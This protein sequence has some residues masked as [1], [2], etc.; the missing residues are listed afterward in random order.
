MTAEAPA[1]FD[2]N[3]TAPVWPAVVAAMA[4]ALTSGGNPSSVHRAGRTARRA[5]E[6]ARAAVAA[7]VGAEQPDSVVFTSGA[8]EAN[9]LALRGVRGRRH[10]V[11]AIEH[12]SVL[13]AAEA[14]KII[15][16]LSSGVIDL[17]ALEDLLAADP[18]PALV[19]LMVANNETGAIQPVAEAARLAHA[20]GALFHCDAV[21]AAGRLPLDIDRLGADLLSLSAHKIGGPSG[22]GALVVSPA[23]AVAP[24]LVGGGQEK[25]R[26]AGTENLAG[27]VGFG[28]AARLSLECLGDM[29]RVATLRNLVAARLQA[30]APDAMIFA[31]DA[32]RLAN[33]LSI[34]MPSVAAATQVMALDLAGVMISAGA[35]CSSGKVRRSAVLDAMGVEAAVAETAIRISLGRDT[36]INDVDRLVDAWTSLYHRTRTSAA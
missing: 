11:S 35:A 18:R 12:P 8:T 22:V 28:V 29:E 6:R 19:S 1:Y 17:D 16:V 36:T 7:L 4:E 14:A 9:H 5:I 15:P 33:T 2:W 25:G 20:H 30:V 23:V 26:R 21:Q 32:P 13:A 24:L 34:A 27:I 3:A 10:L 31:V